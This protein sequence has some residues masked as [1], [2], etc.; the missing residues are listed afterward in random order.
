MKRVVVAIVFVLAII[1][2]LIFTV[3]QQQTKNVTEITSEDLLE[4]GVPEKIVRETE[5]GHREY[6]VLMV[7]IS[8]VLTAFGVFLVI[9]PEKAWELQHLLTVDGGEPTSFAIGGNRF[10]GILMILIA[11][12]IVYQAFFV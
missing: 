10:A 6:Q 1:G 11:L 8:V 9:K 4:A 5:K 2:G 12:Y 3:D 7:V